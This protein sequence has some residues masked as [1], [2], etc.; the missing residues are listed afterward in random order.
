MPPY[1]IP[2]RVL[3][4]AV[5]DKTVVKLA[6]ERKHRTKMVAYPAERDLVGM[7][8]PHYPRAGQKGRTLVQSVLASAGDLWVALSPNSSLQLGSSTIKICC[9]EANSFNPSYHEPRIV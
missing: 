7:V 2:Q 3:S 6:P 4:Q 1:A 9:Q 5:T 8:A